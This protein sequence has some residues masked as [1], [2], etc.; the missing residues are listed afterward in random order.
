MSM[1]MIGVS[2]S[3]ADYNPF[4]QAD[5]IFHVYILVIIT[6]CTDLCINIQQHIIDLVFTITITMVYSLAH[7]TFYLLFVF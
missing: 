5:F 7:S 6:M 2:L 1:Q 4:V 3:L